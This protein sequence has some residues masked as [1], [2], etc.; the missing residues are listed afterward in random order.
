MMPE[1]IATERLTLRRP[2]AADAA[3]VVEMIGELD[4]A[5]WLTPVPHPYDQADA[6][7]FIA[8]FGNPDRNTFLICASGDPVGMV[9]IEEEL[10]YWLGTAHWG[11]G[12]ATEAARAMIARHFVGS[13]DPIQSGYHEGNVR[14]RHVLAKLGF[15]PT[16][17]ETATSRATGETVSI[18]KMTCSRDDWRLA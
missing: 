11:R 14:S 2:E 15:R 13:E 10:G 8:R 12:Y 7:D 3:R 5:R 18:R 6:L 1:T 9:G 4:V 17:V 16:H